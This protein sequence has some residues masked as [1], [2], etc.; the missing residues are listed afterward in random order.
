MLKL[1]CAAMVLGL[2]SGPPAALAQP[3]SGQAAP[4][5]Q[6]ALPMEP[7][8]VVGDVVPGVGPTPGVVLVLDTPAQL[9]GKSAARAAD[10]LIAPADAM[11]ACND[12]ITSGIVDKRDLAATFV[13]RGVLLLTMKRWAEARQDF[14]RALE[15]DP[16]AAEAL[17]NRGA[18][19]L[20][21]GKAAE[22]IADLDRGIAL[23]PERPERAYYQRGMARETLK[24]FK[25]AYADY[26]MA[27]SLRPGW[28]LV[29]V[30]L[31]RFKVVSR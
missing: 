13:N 27:D 29:A 5:G 21:E 18:I 2:A 28:D 22:A 17:V 19:L 15:I 26:K 8:Q 10:G 16:D 1:L 12:A 20:A 6:E 14:D 31:S 3:S 25:G 7:R 9:C 30:E 24:D 23:G 11:T 4:A